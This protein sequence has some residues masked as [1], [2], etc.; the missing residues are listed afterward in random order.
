VAIRER[1]EPVE[2]E[3]SDHRVRGLVERSE[4]PAAKRPQQVGR[5][6]GSSNPPFSAS[7]LKEQLH[8]QPRA[9][10][11]GDTLSGPRLPGVL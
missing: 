6:S 11:T 3:R 1:S 8:T 10:V 5:V 2:G 7:L 4:T 9:V